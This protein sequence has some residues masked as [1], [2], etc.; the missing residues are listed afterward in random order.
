MDPERNVSDAAAISYCR[1]IAIESN[2]LIE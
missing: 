1:I 2:M